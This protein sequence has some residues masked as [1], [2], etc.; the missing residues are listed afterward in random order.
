MSAT[1]PGAAAT[2]L[3]QALKDGTTR[4]IGDMA[5]ELDLSGRQ[6]SDA[7]SKLFARG[8]LERPGI[9]LFKLTN[10]GI[11]AAERGV[12]ITSGPRGAHGTCP[13]RKRTFR[14]RAWQAIRIRRAFTYGDIVADAGQTDEERDL[15][16]AARFVRQLARAGI[17]S[18]VKRRQK[19][20]V[21][22]SNGFKRFILMK[23]LGP[24]APVYRPKLKLF[25][26]FNAGKDWPCDQV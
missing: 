10:E 26:D 22:G 8:F 9:G 19:G 24:R 23:D 11:Q 25:H 4:K 16:N 15:E 5:N 2:M 1:K 6:V 7:A 21:Q 12:K 17:V 20:N 14:Q 3:L 13:Q 18:E